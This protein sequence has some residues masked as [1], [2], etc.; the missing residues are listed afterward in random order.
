M[1]GLLQE[2]AL[3]RVFNAWRRSIRFDPLLSRV[4]I[5]DLHPFSRA[6]NN[7]L[8]G[9]DDG[10]L[11]EMCNDLVRQ[12][13]E[14]HTVTRL[15]T[16]LAE[17]F[18]DEVG[19]T[20]GAVSR[21]LV[22]T[23]GHVCGLMITTMVS[24]ATQLAYRDPLTGLENRR[25]WDEAIAGYAENGRRLAICMIDLDGLKAIN[26][27]QGHD[28]GDRYLSEFASELSTSTP[29]E[30]RAFRLSGGGDEFGVFL[31][32]A[33]V[34][35]LQQVIQQLHVTEGIAPFSYGIASTADQFSKV[36]DLKELAD[37]RMYEMKR[38][39]KG[40]RE[41]STKSVE[42]EQDIVTEGSDLN[43][44]IEPPERSNDSETTD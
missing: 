27:T 25:A 13:L 36:E 21:S 19:N 9:E 14:P 38:E 3:E 28:A 35:D 43:T 31:P 33:D 15:A 44:R 7:A 26:D 42:T 11:A 29:A 2:A 12:R 6:F 23:L 20:S 34:R 5:P 10:E 32:D 30:G 41:T 16:F 24:D 18:A 17:T 39:R 8:T 40:Q 37:A 4:A 22:S 1:P